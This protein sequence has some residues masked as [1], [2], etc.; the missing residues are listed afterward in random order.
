MPAD[1]AAPGAAV[2]W[3]DLRTVPATPWKNG[4]GSTRE[5]VCWPPGA[6]TDAFGWRVSVARI[7]APGPFSAF[8]GV[9]RQ[10]ML[11]D[12]DGVTLHGEQGELCHTLQQRWQPWGFAGE[13]PLDSRLIG[14]PST[15]FN[16]MLRRGQWQGRMQV[17]HDPATV[18]A[19]GA[20]LCMVLQGQWAV[21]GGDAARVLQPGQ[22]LWW[23]EAMGA[24]VLQ[25][26]QPLSPEVANPHPFAPDAR[27][28]L[29]WVDVAPVNM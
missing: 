19:T 6:G 5:L 25:P 14:G 4:G 9:D 22:G 13:Q 28:A 23:P 27:P 20:G 17:L 1:G 26:L 3:F 8:T 29:V 10:I 16:L 15:D 21:L 11:L 18:G 12:G 24:R 7:A 2:H